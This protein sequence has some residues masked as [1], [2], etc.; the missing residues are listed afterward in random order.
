MKE[1]STLES[2]WVKGDDDR[3]NKEKRTRKQPEACILRKNAALV[4]APRLLLRMK[5]ERV[6]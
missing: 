4:N 2:A 1:A 3:R 5:E 6:S